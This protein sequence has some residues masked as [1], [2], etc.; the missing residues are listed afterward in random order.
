MLELT[1]VVT[2]YDNIKVLHGISLAVNKG[3]IVSIVGAN[4]AG[5]TTTLMTISGIV[6]LISGQIFFEGI[7]IDTLPPEERLRL[8]IC[9]TPEGRRIF[10]DLT[11]FENL[12]IG[13]LC[14]PDRKKLDDDFEMVYDIFPRLKERSTQ[15]GG[16]LSGGEQQMLAVARSL[17]SRP[18]LLLLDEPS[19]GLAP[20]IVKIIFDTLLLLRSRGL[21]ILLVEQNVR[22][23][24]K[25]AD[26]AYV[27][28]TG[29]IVK[30][31]SAQ[32]LAGS[33][34]IRKSYLG[35]Q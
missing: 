13:A 21:S 28:E 17:M 30:S 33:D 35:I 8:G 26:R 20:T 9:Q 1:D 7:R 11:V 24:L 31:G 29:N 10:T 2:S 27:L 32:E 15:L 18:K 3:E 16:T 19:L 12:K 4:G 23:A 25:L 34:D 14:R 6:R 22:A 5:K